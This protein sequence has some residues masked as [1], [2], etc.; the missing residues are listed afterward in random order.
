MT[1]FNI[2]DEVT[3]TTRGSRAT[4]EYGPF[5][6]L[7]T[8]V[9]KLVD[10]P[11]DPDDVRTFTALASVM[12]PA[13]AFAIGDKVTADYGRTGNIVA[14]PF[15]SRMSEMEFWIVEDADGKHSAPRTGT[16]AKVTEPEPIKVGDRV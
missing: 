1:K 2:G 16:L 8:Y 7:D 3:L 10:A 6:E 13:P 5:D 9:V 15:I 4:V 11:A 14:G 12:K